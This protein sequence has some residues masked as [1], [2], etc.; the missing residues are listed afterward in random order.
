MEYYRRLADSTDIV[1]VAQGDITSNIRVCD[2]KSIIST[3]PGRDAWLFDNAIDTFGE[4]LNRHSLPVDQ[5]GSFICLSTL[6]FSTI[7]G[8]QNQYPEHS[9]A[10]SWYTHNRMDNPLLRNFIHIPTNLTGTHW[11]TVT[12]DTKRRHIFYVDSMGSS[13]S[14]KAQLYFIRRWLGQEI[15]S[16]LEAGGLTL[17]EAINLGNPKLWTYSVVVTS[18]QQLN[19]KDCGLFYLS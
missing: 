16:Q 18:P 10:A 4:L 2:R 17:Q 11:T 15:A 6:L 8:G 12:I 3:A 13:T 19:G 14:G 1:L 7:V 5:W 9:G